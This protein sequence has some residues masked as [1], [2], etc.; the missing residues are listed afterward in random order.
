MSD[1][2]KEVKQTTNSQPQVTSITKSS[3]LPSTGDKTETHYVV[4]ALLALSSLLF[5]FAG[6]LKLRKISKSLK[7]K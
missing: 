4:G 3:V 5:G 6:K 1:N 2:I 7:E